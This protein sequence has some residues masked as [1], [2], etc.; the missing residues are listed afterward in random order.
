MIKFLD[1]KKINDRQ[2]KEIS[3]AIQRVLDSGWYVLGSEVAS[4]EKEFAEFHGV[5]YALA[6]S[7]GLDALKI[8]I[9]A[10]IEKGL[11]Q[12][13]DEILVPANTFIASVLAISDAKLKPVLVDISEKDYLIDSSKIEAKISSKTKGIMN[14]HLYGQIS[15]DEKL[16]QIIQKHQLIHIEDNAQAIGANLN[17]KKSGNIGHA[18][19]V[20]FYPGK[21]LGA[22][23]D[24]GAILTNDKT[25]YRIGK[26]LANYGSEKKY[27]HDYQGFNNRMDELQAAVLRVKLP[28]INQDNQKRQAIA[29]RFV[30]GISNPKIELPEIPTDPSKHVWHLFVI[31]CDKRQKL[32]EYLQE[33]GIQSLIHYPIP[34]HQQKSYQSLFEGEKYPI[35]EQLS[36]EIL[37]IPISP[38]LEDS[39]VETIINTLNKF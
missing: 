32:Q 9:R 37:S 13:G 2:E 21:N 4:F 26:S 20:S 11:F 33:N 30:D 27:I 25:L 12:E 16:D 17:G 36:E 8:I 14:V 31:R 19:A 23:G 34:V 28:K 24:A 38:I 1:I 5:K 29:K 6:T 10:Y 39:E 22:L 15:Y 7:N 3:Q 18:A 35:T